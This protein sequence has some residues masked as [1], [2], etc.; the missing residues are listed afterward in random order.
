MWQK[1]M[2]GGWGCKS[3]GGHS[4]SAT[5]SKVSPLGFNEGKRL[6]ERESLCQENWSGT[7]SNCRSWQL[8]SAEPRTW[9]GWLVVM[10]AVCHLSRMLPAPL[11]ALHRRSS[12]FKGHFEFHVFPECTAKSIGLKSSESSVKLHLL[13]PTGQSV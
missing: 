8:P 12:R 11:S 10:A 5:P 1:E 4:T 9:H 6:R 3:A 2:L 7:Q 13:W